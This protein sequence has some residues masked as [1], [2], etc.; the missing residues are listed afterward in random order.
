LQAILRK[1]TLLTPGISMGLW[2]L[3]KRPACE[4]SSGL[5]PNRSC[6]LKVAEPAVTS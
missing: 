6:P 4:R 2:K 1:S 5:S 3:R